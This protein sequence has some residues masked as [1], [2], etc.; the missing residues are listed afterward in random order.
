MELGAGV[1]GGH[2]AEPGSNVVTHAASLGPAIVRA[3]AKVT[4]RWSGHKVKFD[5]ESASGHT[6]SVDEAPIFGDDEAMRPTEMLLGALGSC[7]G[8]NAVLLLKK[9]KQPFKSLAVEVEGEQE[10]DWPRRFTTIEITFVIG[11]DGKH[12]K[13]EVDHALDMA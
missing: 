12:D 6:A 8:L 7:T 2:R 3:V 5:I 10:K 1:V 9:F 11:W 13:D 4:A